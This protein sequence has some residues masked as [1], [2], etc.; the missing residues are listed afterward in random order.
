MQNRGT[1]VDNFSIHSNPCNRSW[2][3]H[4]TP[5]LSVAGSIPDGVI[6]IFHWLNPSDPTIAIGVDS[7]SS[8]NEYQ[9]FLLRVKVAGT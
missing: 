7:A 5:S 3:R 4:C 2:L 8:R 1:A 6:G 9:D